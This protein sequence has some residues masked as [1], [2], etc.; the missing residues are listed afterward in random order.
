MLMLS[1]DDQRSAQRTRTLLHKESLLCALALLFCFVA[2][3]PV[4]EIGVNDDWSYILTTQAFVHTHRF[5]YNG[6][7]SAMLGWQVLWG[8]AF[9]RIFGP[10]FTAI[11]LSVIPIALAIAILYYAVLRNF[12]LD[13]AHA[14]FGTLTLVLSPV[15]IPLSATFMTD[16]PGLFIVLLCIYLCQRALSA[17]DGTRAVLW[18]I[19]AALTNILGGTVRQIAWLGVL[20]IVPSCGW[21]L[22]RW[23]YV[24]P[25]TVVTWLVGI[26]SIKLLL[27][28]FVRQP[29]SLPEPLFPEPLHRAALLHLLKTFSRL[30]PITLL[31]ALPVLIAGA[32]AAWPLRRAQ[33]IRALA[34]PAM[35]LG[36]YLYLERIGRLGL[37]D[38]LCNGNI[39]T[40]WGIMQG[41]ELFPSAHRIPIQWMVIFFGALFAC[42]E[43]FVEALVRSRSLPAEK[44]YE[45]R[46]SWQAMN[47]LL[48]PF[49]ISYILLL[50]PRAAFATLFD[51]YLLEVIA[52]LLIY[53]L[54][55]HQERAGARIPGIATA[56][57]AVIPLLTVAS[58]HDLFS[59][60]RAE[61]R[62][63]NRML[64]AGVPRTQIRGGFDY[65]TVTEVYTTGYVNYPQIVNPP[66]A[67]RPLLTDESGPCGDPFLLY[68]PAMHIRYVITPAMTTCLAPTDFAPESYRTWLPPARRD[69]FVGL[70]LPPATAA[71]G[72]P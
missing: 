55:W 69:V 25:V 12:S 9:A 38:S 17:P 4:A 59:R 46:H 48:L 58:T 51:R 30:V 56:S 31:L 15:F 62:L 22:R 53:M 71:A 36:V 23:R 70:R 64:Q 44:D 18:L 6:W 49:L 27:A 28:W 32:A 14:R 52:V 1:R 57:L 39:V 67:F 11:R 35:L 5:V 10:T 13:R 21:L 42:T 16:V 47:L 40:P 3:W 43:L 45:H 2:I 19:A 54:R 34:P 68:L 24:I 37:L 63:T 65:D 60:A 8:A 20:V 66:G 61:V 41:P 72:K 26:I 50:C 7:A 29:Y 33:V